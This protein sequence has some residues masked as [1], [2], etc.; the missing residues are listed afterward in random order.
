MPRRLP[1]LSCFRQSAR[2]LIELDLP[3][4]ALGGLSL[5]EPSSVTYE[6]VEVCTELLPANKPRYLMGSGY[7][8]DIVSAVRRGIDMFD[9]VLPTRNGR[10]GTAFTSQGR[11]TIRN[12]KH[13]ADPSPLDPECDC[14]TCRE[15]TRSYLR[16][17]FIAGEALGPHLLTLHNIHYFIDLVAR[18]RGHI[19]QGDFAAW[20]EEFLAHSSRQTAHGPSELEETAPCFRPAKTGAVPDPE[21]AVTGGNSGY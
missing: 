19:E 3:G 11:V 21:S 7:P 9:C 10:T 1:A 18:I 15:F 8:E 13:I 4:Y 16:H 5:G 12:A 6:M 2:D 17:L 20:S 14:Y